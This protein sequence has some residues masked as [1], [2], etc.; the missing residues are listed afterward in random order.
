MGLWTM[1][2]IISICGICG[3]VAMAWIKENKSSEA[4][5]EDNKK[6]QGQVSNLEERIKVLEAIVTD[7]KFD[8]NQKINELGQ[9]ENA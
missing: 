8:L 6:L 9:K 5:S 7:S 3:S 1:V 2:A 4:A